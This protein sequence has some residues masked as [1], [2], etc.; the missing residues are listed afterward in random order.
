MRI[1]TGSLH[2]HK[3]GEYFMIQ[4]TKTCGIE[5]DK[6]CWANNAVP[7]PPNMLDCMLN[8][9]ILDFVFCLSSCIFLVTVCLIGL[10]MVHKV[11]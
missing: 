2:Y 9:I 3:Q 7:L 5:V 6:M 4:I 10:H 11:T 1:I 8:S